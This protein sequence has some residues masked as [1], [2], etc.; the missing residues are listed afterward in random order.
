MSQ[1]VSGNPSIDARL[2]TLLRDGVT[3]YLLSVRFELRLEFTGEVAHEARGPRVCFT[4]RARL[5]HPF[6][7]ETEAWLTLTD[8]GD[9]QLRF[10]CPDPRRTLDNDVRSRLSPPLR[11]TYDLLVAPYLAVLAGSTVILSSTAE[12][13]P[14]LGAILAGCNFY[15]PARLDAISPTRELCRTFPAAGLDSRSLV[16]HLGC[17]ASPA[18]TFVIEG[19][20]ILDA[21]LGTPAAVLDSITL[22]VDQESEA[23]AACLACRFTVKLGGEALVCIG[24]LGL[25]S[26]GRV[27][28]AGSLDAEDGVWD[29]PFGA[30]GLAVT[31]LGLQIVAAKNPPYLG[32]GAR[33][34]ARIGR[35]S[36]DAEFALAFDPANP[37][38]SVLDLRSKSGFDL[39]RLL[40]AMVDNH[41]LPADLLRARITDL[42]LTISPEGAVIANK[43]Y[44]PGFAV[45]GNLELW[46]LRAA[47]D[48]Q[49]TYAGGGH[50]HAAASPLRLP[51][52]G[53]FVDIHGEGSDGP[54]MRIDCNAARQGAEAH[55]AVKIVG[56]YDAAADVELDARRLH[57]ALARTDLGVY[58]G[59]SFEL[60]RARATVGFQAGFDADLKIRL[61]RVP[62]RLA[63]VVQAALTAQADD[64]HFQQRGT[65]E[66]DACGQ[67]LRLQQ[68]DIAVRF[69]DLA[70]L[71]DYFRRCADA[72]AALIGHALVSVSQAA[73]AWL[74]DQ[75]PDLQSVSFILHDVG[76][77]CDAAMAGLHTAYQLSADACAT[78]LRLAAYTATQIAG[79]LHAVYDLGEQATGA[80]LS[81]I[82][83]SSSEVA[84]AMRGAFGWSA[85]KTADFLHDSLHVSDKAAKK[86]LDAAGYSTS[87][88]KG[89]M[90]DAYDWTDSMFDDF[91]GLFG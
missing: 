55:A 67:R 84:G 7:L 23:L 47:V 9:Y 52:N 35:D 59:G 27:T 37:A 12:E 75:V 56:L 64:D 2:A 61:G 14:E 39:A 42:Q 79:A 74:R 76:A 85:R 30:T 21:E 25:D 46:G 29:A 43:E 82:G 72:V 20:L 60:T 89:A 38:K 24:S 81:A 36:L 45:G 10:V 31:G 91:V 86:A 77:A 90:K 62:L 19:S 49:F 4:G 87:Q 51:A 53:T 32:F 15:R 6:D 11:S 17:I 70:S 1:I 80:L 34:G 44:A 33:G 18:F 78:M 50:L 13:D 88:V 3:F 68:P 58:S 26:A 63:L 5:G 65:F 41:H 22:R 69:T 16:L 40:T 71:T 8:D 73:L 66:F 54:S 83:A 28:I 57:F 48:G